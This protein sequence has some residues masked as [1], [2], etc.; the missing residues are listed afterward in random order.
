[1]SRDIKNVVDTAR[2]EGME[3]GIEQRTFEIARQMKK[4]GEPMDKI[5]KYTGLSQEAIE[6]L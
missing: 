4:D 2:A 1:M 3:K 5:Q 6:K